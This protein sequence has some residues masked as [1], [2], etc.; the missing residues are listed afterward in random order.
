[1]P[2][3]LWDLCTAG[4]LDV[5]G[6]TEH[7]VLRVNSEVARAAFGL[8]LAL[9]PQVVHHGRGH[10]RATERASVQFYARAGEQVHATLGESEL[11]VAELAVE[12]NETKHVHQVGVQAFQLEWLSARR[13]VSATFQPVFNTLPIENLLT[14]ATLN[15]LFRHRLANRANKRIY[16]LAFDLNS[17]F[18]GEF[19]AASLE[20]YV[21]GDMFFDRVHESLRVRHVV[22]VEPGLAGVSR[23][24]AIR[25]R[26]I[27]LRLVRIIVGH[28][29]YAFSIDFVEEHGRGH[30]LGA[31]S[32]SFR[33]DGTFSRDHDFPVV[34]KLNY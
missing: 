4:A 22:L 11:A 30:D 2:T 20:N 9:V 31:A 19:G 29:A 34:F 1:M 3:V 5:R 33:Y 13:T 24:P 32:T 18:S 26:E 15:C 14:V 25:R 10:S 6:A 23:R 8:S 17:V 27:F 16:K 12:S 28:S 21:I 7:V